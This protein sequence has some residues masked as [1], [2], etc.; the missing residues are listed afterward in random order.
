MCAAA[1]VT[2]AGLERHPSEH[3]FSGQIGNDQ[4]I[5]D[6]Q[7]LLDDIAGGAPDWVTVG[8]VE[9]YTFRRR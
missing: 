7:K 8:M 9:K 3:G 5:D 4:G 1:P 2:R 6:L